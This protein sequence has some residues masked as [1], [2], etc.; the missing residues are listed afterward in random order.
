MKRERTMSVKEIMPLFI[1]EMGLRAGLDE[2]HVSALWDEL[3]GPAVASATKQ[4]RLKDGKLYVKIT[5]SVA[6]NWLFTERTGIVR[7]INESMGKTLVT[8]IILY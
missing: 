4:K 6:R 2:A 3:L 7:K 5:S 1:E 8:D